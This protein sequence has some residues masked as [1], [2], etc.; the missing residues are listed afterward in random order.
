MSDW[1]YCKYTGEDWNKDLELIAP[2]GSGMIRLSSDGILEVGAEDYGSWASGGDMNTAFGR[3]T[4]EQAIELSTYLNCVSIP[5][6][7]ENKNE[8]ERL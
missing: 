4:L 3:L 6:L 7:E 5:Y 8:L 2:G 1:E